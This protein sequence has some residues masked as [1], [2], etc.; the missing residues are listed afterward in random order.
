MSR[1]SNNATRCVIILERQLC[2][3]LKKSFA[4]DRIQYV[5]LP[6]GSGMVGTPFDSI[7]NY[8]GQ[9]VAIEAKRHTKFKAFHPNELRENQ[10]RGLNAA[11]ASGGKAVVILFIWEKGVR[12]IMLWWEWKDF[13]LL[14]N[15]LTESIKRKDIE[16]RQSVKCIKQR[17]QLSEFYEW[18]DTFYL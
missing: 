4:E 9:F 7:L 12:N 16:A 3:L 18:L 2:S 13:K 10:V 1:L 11:V 15:N 14:T 5:D 8:H 17:Y 6:D